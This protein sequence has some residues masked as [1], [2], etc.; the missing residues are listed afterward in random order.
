MRVFKNSPFLEWDNAITWLHP[1][2]P[3]ASPAEDQEKYPHKSN[4]ADS[5]GGQL[6]CTG[7]PQPS[8]TLRETSR[9]E[10]PPP[11]GPGAMGVGGPLPGLWLQGDSSFSFPR[12]KWASQPFFPFQEGTREWLGP[13]LQVPAFPQTNSSGETT[14]L[15]STT[16]GRKLEGGRGNGRH[17]IREAQRTL[18]SHHEHTRRDAGS[19]SIP[20]FPLTS[21]EALPQIPYL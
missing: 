20:M 11:R 15:S 12:R 2:P 5:G 4:K 21:R 19:G 7:V 13:S 14:S 17:R 6:D 1:L 18:E 9:R 8:S 10:V 16:W 3:L